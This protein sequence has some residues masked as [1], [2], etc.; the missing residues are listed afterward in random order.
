MIPDNKDRISIPTTFIIFGATGDLVRR[1]IAISLLRLYCKGFM[2]EKF[3]VLAISRRDYSNKQFRDF[4]FENS[5][6]DSKFEFSK[7]NIENFLKKIIYIKGY[8]NEKSTYEKIKN[9]LHKNT[10]GLNFCDNKLY[11]LAVP[12]KFYID[13]FK[14]IWY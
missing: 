10:N 8:F 3:Q 2:P 1:K 12:P 5:L 11:Y 14:N 6:I 13:I 4:I 9:Q 7:K